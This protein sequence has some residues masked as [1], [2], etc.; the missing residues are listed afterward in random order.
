MCVQ[1]EEMEFLGAQSGS[2]SISK[3]ASPHPLF[4]IDTQYT[5]VLVCC[6]Q[7][8]GGLILYSS[9]LSVSDTLES[10]PSPAG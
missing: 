7:S 2:I 1:G 5:H 3:L 6:Y 9:S 10:W 4:Y 8:S